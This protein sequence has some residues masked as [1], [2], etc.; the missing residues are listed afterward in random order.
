MK[1]SILCLFNPNCIFCV[2][3]RYLG[4]YITT[5]ERK[6]IYALICTQLRSEISSARERL[7]MRVNHVKNVLVQFIIIKQ[8]WNKMQLE[9]KEC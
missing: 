5:E 6:Y 9:G 8:C 2:C 1:C 4:E 7:L 3:K